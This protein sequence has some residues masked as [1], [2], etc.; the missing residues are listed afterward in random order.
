MKKYLSMLLCLAL[1]LTFFPGA[2][3]ARRTGAA[4]FR[5][6]GA[7][8]RILSG[9]FSLHRGGTAHTERRSSGAKDSSARIFGQSKTPQT[10]CGVF[11]AL[12]RLS[13]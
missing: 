8:R 13:Y 5:F 4:V 7:E 1:M 9:G 3:R 10:D 6:A 2:A 12:C 11:P